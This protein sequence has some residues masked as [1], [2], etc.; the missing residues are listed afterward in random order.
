M[1][2]KRRE[3]P[4]VFVDSRD[5]IQLLEHGRPVPMREFAAE[6]T[7]RRGRVVLSQSNVVELIPQ[8]DTVDAE[9]RRVVELL[10]KLEQLP[11]IYIRIPS[12]YEEFT[13][14]LAAYQTGSDVQTIDPYVEYWWETFFDT[15]LFIARA[16][17]PADLFRYLTSIPLSQQLDIPPEQLRKFRLRTGVAREISEAV[18]ADRN[19]FGVGRDTREEMIAAITRD[20]ARWRWPPPRGGF[21]DF[22]VFVRNTPNACPSWRL[23]FDLYHEYRADPAYR[24]RSGD[25]YDLS[26][27]ETLPYVTHMTLDKFWRDLCRRAAERLSKAGHSY[28]HFAKVYP[29]LKEIV[30]SWHRAG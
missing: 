30:E 21:D 16:V 13:A 4:R 14:A 19:Q 27:A 17:Y 7:I 18:K 3:G 25:I 20:F 8:N 11:H 22:A 15:P 6:L 29:S 9:R 26:H 24:P 10:R 2:F 12:W 1:H 28:P 5:L 23:R